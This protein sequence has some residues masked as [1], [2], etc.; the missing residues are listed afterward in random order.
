MIF[1]LRSVP[2][3]AAVCRRLVHGKGKKR[4]TCR[5]QT[6][7]S[8]AHRLLQAKLCVLTICGFA[9]TVIEAQHRGLRQGLAGGQG[10]ARWIASNVR[11]GSAVKC[12]ARSMIASSS[13]SNVQHAETALSRGH[14]I[15]E[16]RRARPPEST[17]DRIRSTRELM[18]S[19]IA[20]S[21]ASWPPTLH[22]PA[23][24]AMHAALDSAFKFIGR[25]ALHP[26][27]ER[28]TPVS[29]EADTVRGT[30]WAR[31]ARPTSRCLLRL[32]AQDHATHL[33]PCP[34][35]RRDSS[36]TTV[37]RSVTRV[38][39][40][41]LTARTTSLR[42]FLNSRMP[43]VFIGRM[44][45]RAA[46]LSSGPCNGGRDLRAG[47]LSARWNGFDLHPGLVVPA[48]ERERLDASVR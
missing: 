35:P 14:P 3:L 8:R 17:P 31:W 15:P 29:V 16:A 7:Q 38:C 5:R 9:D 33:R 36:A 12:R 2:A 18:R 25:R 46:T 20:P 1:D 39:S 45:L 10:V 11:T 34:S 44:S 32:S 27:G 40:P 28:P 21:R 30:E 13:V 48:G 37:P 42:R 6:R 22:A 41:A 26:A 23:P 24:A 4:A 47:P 43:I 19:R